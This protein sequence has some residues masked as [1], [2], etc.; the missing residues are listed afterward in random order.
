M[1]TL[2]L[3]CASVESGESAG[4]VDADEISDTDDGDD[5]TNAGIEINGE[6]ASERLPAPEFAAVNRDG[7]GRNNGYLV[8]GPTVLWFYSVA[9]MP[10]CGSGDCGFTDTQVEF[11]DLGVELIG[12]S[13][14]EPA[15]NQ[16]LAQAVGFD[17][18]LWTDTD[19]TLALYYGAIVNENE[20][21]P[22]PTIRLLDSN[23]V[24][25]ALYGEAHSEEV[26]RVLEDCAA[27]FGEAE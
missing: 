10:G 26:A 25:T 12:V 6:W 18:E 17:F 3:A 16:E 14:D 8:D 24:L 2:L 4:A 13:F 20:A 19:R 23:G 22:Q 1:F 21:A 5:G 15:A 7:V 9:Q 11:A 27:L